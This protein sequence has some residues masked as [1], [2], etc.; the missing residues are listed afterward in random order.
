MSS[1]LASYYCNYYTGL[2]R[3]HHKFNKQL[4]TMSSQ[5]L[6]SQSKLLVK[7][8]VACVV[9]T[10]GNLT[11]AEKP[12]DK[13]F[14]ILLFAKAVEYAKS[15]RINID[16]GS[17]LMKRADFFQ[18]HFPLGTIASNI[19]DQVK[20]EFDSEGKADDVKHV[21]NLFTRIKAFARDHAAA[22]LKD[23]KKTRSGT[24]DDKEYLKESLWKKIVTKQLD[25]NALKNVRYMYF[26]PFLLCSLYYYFSRIL[27]LRGYEKFCEIEA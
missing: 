22:Y 25:L 16:Y 10:A 24:Y 7:C 8:L 2:R 20:A 19:L 1:K 18:P 12:P 21:F 27:G 11:T 4:E 15:G 14:A 9:A 17:E 6:T 13:D 26:V 23:K 3:F 5:L